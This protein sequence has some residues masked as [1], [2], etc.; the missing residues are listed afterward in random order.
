MK[1]TILS[2]IL[3]LI[4]LN[5]IAQIK[6]GIN[7]GFGSNREF[8]FIENSI[9]RVKLKELQAASSFQ[10]GVGCYFP[11]TNKIEIATELNF[12]DKAINYNKKRADKLFLEN[13]I[14]INFLFL[15]YFKFSTGTCN[16]VFIS[17]HTKVFT[18]LY[19]CNIID[20]KII[21]KCV[22]NIK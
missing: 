14:N 22:S 15:K 21:C 13:Q 16:N 7:T 11:I 17:T 19:I 8:L 3:I 5:T 20:N 6:W 9:E 12:F 2:V 4:T 18:C 1:K 10:I